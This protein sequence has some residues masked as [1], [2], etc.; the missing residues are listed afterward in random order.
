MADML[1]TTWV[2]PGELESAKLM[3]VSIS[4]PK[5]IVLAVM[6]DIVN[7]A[8]ARA[9][10]KPGFAPV[11][12]QRATTT[13]WNPNLRV[14]IVRALNK[15][16]TAVDPSKHILDFTDY[17]TRDFCLN[18]ELVGLIREHNGKPADFWENKVECEF[19]D[20][21]AKKFD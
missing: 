2:E 13:D 12:T 3:G 16:A 18:V 20:C 15:R 19:S 5:S 1:A 9:I 21:I 14:D 6:D 11:L 7:L 4:A 10:Q 17:V 8:A